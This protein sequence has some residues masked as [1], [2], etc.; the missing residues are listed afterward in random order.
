MS[1]EDRKR[2][3]E[4]YSVKAVPA[5][6]QPDDWLVNRAADVSPGKALELACGLGHNALWLAEQG[7]QVDAVDVSPVG[8]TMAR[9]LA[10]DVGQTVNWLEADLDEFVPEPGGYTLAVVFRFLDR[11]RLP[12]LIPAAVAP[13]GLLIYETFAAGQLD[14]A[15]NHLH[16]AAY[17]LSTGELPT[18]YPEFDVV[19]YREDQLEDRTVAR[20]CARRSD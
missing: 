16:N 9:Q 8:L 17:V 7:W 18:L 5:R 1:H 20:L 14:R 3:D 19:E 10:D 13:G 2:W 6:V 11:K 4:K 15:D 12:T